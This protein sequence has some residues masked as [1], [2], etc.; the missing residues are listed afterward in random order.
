MI[1]RMAGLLVAV[2]ALAATVSV[3]AQDSID[4]ALACTHACTT[5]REYKGHWLLSF[6]DDAGRLIEVAQTDVPVSFPL[7]EKIL[8]GAFP[9]AYA[10]DGNKRRSASIQDTNG[11]IPGPPAGG[12]GT[13]T[14][15]FTGP[16]V[17]GGTGGVWVVTITYTYV[18]FNL[19]K[20]QTSTHFEPRVEPPPTMEK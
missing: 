10:N 15:T 16:G 3:S 2:S 13:V 4:E 12:T 1:H 7:D 14:E 6:Y 19:V 5:V 20:I 11:A 18:D 9:K 8:A 17:Q